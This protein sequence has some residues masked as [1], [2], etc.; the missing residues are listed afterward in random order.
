MEKSLLSSSIFIDPKDL[1][2]GKSIGGNPTPASL[3]CGDEH[4]RRRR[5]NCKEEALR[6]QHK[7]WT[8]RNEWPRIG[9]ILWAIESAP[10]CL[11]TSREDKSVPLIYRITQD[12]PSKGGDH[13]CALKLYRI[14]HKEDTAFDPVVI[15]S[16]LLAWM[17]LCNLHNFF[18]NA[19]F[20]FILDL[21]HI[22][23]ILP[24]RGVWALGFNTLVLLQLCCRDKVNYCTAHLLFSPFFFCLN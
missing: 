18:L 15:N 10:I 11:I 14:L 24:R 19:F 16:F 2:K 8:T 23:N 3:W 12:N 7:S 5:G 6:E 4:R 1:F 22:T 13:H 17:D 9:N 21:V 20:V